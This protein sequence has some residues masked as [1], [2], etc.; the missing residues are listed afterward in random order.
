MDSI[1]EQFKFSRFLYCFLLYPSLAIFH[2]FY[3]FSLR[4]LP[5]SALYRGTIIEGI[6]FWCLELL[7]WRQA[8][9]GVCVTRKGGTGGVPGLCLGSTFN[10]AA[11]CAKIALHLIVRACWFAD[12]YKSSAS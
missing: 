9:T 4:S 1:V 3:C 2:S 11:E 8:R 5:K 6:V 10:D 12:W 7:K